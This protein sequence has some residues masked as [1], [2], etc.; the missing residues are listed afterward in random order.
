MKRS[1]IILQTLVTLGILILGLFL[2]GL[3]HADCATPP[4]GLVGWWKGDGSTLD[5]IAANNGANQNVGF[6]SGVV[7]QAFAFDPENLPYGTYSGIQIADK[8]AYALTN[9]LTIEGWIR[10]RGAGYL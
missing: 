10:P 1:S 9:S 8:P 4:A 7:G 5:S 6:S 3:A 2:N